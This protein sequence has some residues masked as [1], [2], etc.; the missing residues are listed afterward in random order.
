MEQR[1]TPAELMG[2]L[3]RLGCTELFSTIAENQSGAILYKDLISPKG[4]SIELLIEYVV[5]EQAGNRIMK[6]ISEKFG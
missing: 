5:I 2:V 1:I 6:F 3:D 4:L